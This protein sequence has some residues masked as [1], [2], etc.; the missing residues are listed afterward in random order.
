[1]PRIAIPILAI[2]CFVASPLQVHAQAPADASGDKVGHLPHVDFIPAKRQV[3]VECEALGVNAPLEFYCCVRGTNEH[4]SVLRTD[5]KPSHIFTALLAIGLKPGRPISYDLQQK[6]WYPPTGPPLHVSVEFEKDGKMVSYPAFR[7]LRDIKN[8]KEPK[9]FSW[10]FTGSR[11]MPDGKFAA[12]VTG[13]VMSIV[14]FDLTLID[15]PD[16][17]SSANETLEWERN[18]DLMPKVGTKVWMVIEPAGQ[19]DAAHDQKRATTQPA[20]TSS[21]SASADNLPTG[22]IASIDENKI[23]A[24]RKYWQEKVGANTNTLREAAAAHAQ[25]IA[26]LRK[27]QQRLIEE[28]DRVQRTIDQLEKDY[29]DLTTAPSAMDHGS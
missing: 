13:Y 14:N 29:Q 11:V 23:A 28:S 19:V 20:K 18:A 24:L 12:D 1:M 7:W 8:K 21:P 9:A 16:F 3:R 27:E 26:A 6:K 5:A 4:E 2:I 25:V 10:V 17:A 15:I 22:P